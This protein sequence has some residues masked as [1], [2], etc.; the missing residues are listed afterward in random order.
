MGV[1]AH[2]RE[3]EERKSKA[4]FNGKRANSKKYQEIEELISAISADI[5]NGVQ[6]SDIIIKLKEG[7]YKEQ[8]HPYKESTA[9]NYYWAATQRLKEDREEDMET[10]KD[11]LYSQ[12]YQLY[13]DAMMVGNTIGAKSV[14]DSIAKLFLPVQ[15]Q[16]MNIEI[17]NNSEKIN[18]SF[19]FDTE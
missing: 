12:Y 13:T 14:L 8:T 7:L 1:T 9:V 3:K 16:G 4:F 18:I 15:K 5:V 10:L 2:L 11:K 17:D 19:G 6:R